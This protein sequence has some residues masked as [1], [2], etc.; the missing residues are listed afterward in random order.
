MLINKCRMTSKWVLAATFLLS[1]WLSNGFAGGTKEK[2][3]SVIAPAAPASA[4]KR[5][6][7]ADPEAKALLE[8]F[9]AMKTL[10]GIPRDNFNNSADRQ[11][12]GNV[13]VQNGVASFP[14][15]RSDAIYIYYGC[16]MSE[17][18][19]LSLDFRVDQLPKDHNFMTL[20][21]VGSGGNI[22]FTVRLGLDMRVKITVTNQQYQNIQLL[23]EPV[24]LGKWHKVQW[25]YAPEGAVLEVDGEIHD[26]S[27]DNSTQYGAGKGGDAFY[28]GDQPWWD[29]GGR[30][31]VFYPLDS[32][33]G[34]IDNV[35][36][37][38]LQP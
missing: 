1:G 7:D 36:L 33:V 12:T 26:Y 16:R 10:K 19:C 6:S 5:H 38:A 2:T 27:T 4:A 17:R 15:D 35:S 13:A 34:L 30:R 29:A 11:I 28:L 24:K 22:K 18:G 9:Q 3:A 31:D 20:C 37:D 32:F 14:E 23:G 8:K 21:S 25:W